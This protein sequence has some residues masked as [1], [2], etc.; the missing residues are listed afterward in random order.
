MRSTARAALVALIPG[1]IALPTSAA[2]QAGDNPL[3]SSPG[4]ALSIPSEGAAECRIVPVYEFDPEIPN[5]GDITT[6]E[7]RYGDA[8]DGP[9]GRH[10]R[11]IMLASDTAGSPVLLIA[12][13]HRYDSDGVPLGS[14]QVIAE[15]RRDGSATGVLSTVATDGAAMASA[16]AEGD[17][18]KMRLAMKPG[19][20]RTLTADEVRRVRALAAH[21]WERRCAP[22][23]R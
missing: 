3:P 14:E 9:L 7:F 10:P 21:L 13:V 6:R 15:F 4:N 11:E 20:P 5:R 22:A 12:E 19:D 8:V 1:F 2:A 17:A 23:Q 16:V 18:G